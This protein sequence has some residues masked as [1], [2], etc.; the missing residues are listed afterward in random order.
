M[1]FDAIGKRL[2]GQ[3]RFSESENMT[4][5]K[6][7]ENKNIVVCHFNMLGLW[8]NKTYFSLVQYWNI[9]WCWYLENIN[10]RINLINIAH[11]FSCKYG[12]FWSA[13]IQRS[14][15]ACYDRMWWQYLK[16]FLQD[17]Q[18][19]TCGVASGTV[20]PKVYICK[21]HIFLLRFKQRYYYF[22]ITFARQL[23]H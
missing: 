15:C 17:R 8:Y 11:G 13:F 5:G 4:C 14:F 16:K 20:L 6:V 22:M 2:F 7:L 10:G 23:M 12:L 19:F 9:C 1:C 18:W 21:Y 3:K